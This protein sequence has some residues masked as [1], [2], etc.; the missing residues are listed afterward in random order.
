MSQGPPTPPRL[1]HLPLE[2][3]TRIQQFAPGHQG[4]L[5]DWLQGLA[6]ELARGGHLVA[7]LRLWLR[8]ADLNLPVAYRTYWYVTDRWVHRY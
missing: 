3:Y 6:E 4:Q 8:A 5:W 7:D 1:F 2:A